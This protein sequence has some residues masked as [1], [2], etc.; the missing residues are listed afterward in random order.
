M[1]ALIILTAL[2]LAV[3]IL[4]APFAIWLAKP[5]PRRRTVIEYR[6]RRM[7]V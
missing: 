6:G 1:T 2:C 7:V 3:V 4:Y 5:I